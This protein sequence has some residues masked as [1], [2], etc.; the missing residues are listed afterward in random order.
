MPALLATQLVLARCPHCGVDKPNLVHSGQF[1]PIAYN[2][3]RRYWRVYVCVRCA[4][5]VSAEAPGW[6]H[7]TFAI[8]PSPQDVSEDLPVRARA[9]LDQAISSLSAP[10][11]AVMLAASAVDAM[12]KAKNLNSGS[13][14]ARIDEAA[15]THLITAEMAEWAHDVRLDANDQ[16]HADDELPLPDQEQA[17][18]CV[19]FALAL[20]QFM[21]VL[22]ARVQRGIKIAKGQQ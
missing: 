13:L 3:Q 9:Y 17:K 2:T 19:E 4:G 1:E 21:F 22:P 7:D 14:Y 18:K 5:L 16:R 12:L 6:D 8:F 20:G 11:G 10:A 15:K